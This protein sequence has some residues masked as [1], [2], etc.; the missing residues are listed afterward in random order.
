VPYDWRVE[1]LNLLSDAVITAVG[2]A[3]KDG[4]ICG[5]QAF[6]C[7]GHGPEPCAFSDL[8]SYLRTVK[9]SRPG[10]W[11][12]LWSVEALARQSVLLIWKQAAPISQVEL[13]EVKDWLN[14]DFGREFLA[15]GCPEPGASPETQWG[16]YDH[17]EAV[18][19]LAYRCAATGV[20]AVLP[21]SDL[22]GQTGRWIPT[23][24]LVDAKRPNERGEVPLGGAY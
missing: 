24:H 7:A 22:V 16:D 15:V 3:L 2:E 6:Y 10:D 19:E 8:D 5:V 4:I 14:S 23:L 11:Y 21:L 1:P 17:F 13:K 9:A 18:Q 20:F 12:T